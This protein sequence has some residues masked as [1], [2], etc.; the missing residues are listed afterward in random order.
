MLLLRS[1]GIRA[2]TRLQNLAARIPL[3][4]IQATQA[5]TPKHALSIEFPAVTLFGI[6]RRNKQMS[7]E[8]E[9]DFDGPKVNDKGDIV[10]TFS[11][12][13]AVYIHSFV[14]FLSFVE[15]FR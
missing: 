7:A 13:F 5:P 12:L 2:V 1:S 9:H 6:H 10:L 15:G 4:Q 8:K 14:S 3:V 11:T